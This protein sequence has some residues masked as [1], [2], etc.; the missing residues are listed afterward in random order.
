MQLGE[1]EEIAIG[2]HDRVTMLLCEIMNDFVARF[3]L[4]AEQPDVGALKEIC[5]RRHNPM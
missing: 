2:S 1:F 3:T 5:Y 4:K